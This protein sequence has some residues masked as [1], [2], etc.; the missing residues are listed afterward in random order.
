MRP[1][2]E[3]D[4]DLSNEERVIRE[5]SEYAECDYEKGGK[6]DHFDFRVRS[7]R[8]PLN[9]TLSEVKVRTNDRGAYP[10]YMISAQKIIGLVEQARREGAWAVLVV[11]WSDTGPMGINLYD[12]GKGNT[13][14]LNSQFCGLE[15]GG[16]LDRNDPKDVELVFHFKVDRFRVLTS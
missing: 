2:Y 7:I 14:L 13:E 11:K 1:R 10:T 6:W 9:V 5:I 16:R 15:F 3:S 8:N 12:P 4:Q